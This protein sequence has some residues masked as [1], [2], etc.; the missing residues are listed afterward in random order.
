MV[1]SSGDRVSRGYGGQIRRRFAGLDRYGVKFLCLQNGSFHLLPSKNER[2]SESSNDACL[3]TLG[4]ML[5]A[6]AGRKGRLEVTQSA[7]V[8]K[9]MPG[10]GN[11]A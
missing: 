6:V 2:P 10:I 8:S 7:R 5:Q 1:V 4:A 11:S 3:L 9:V